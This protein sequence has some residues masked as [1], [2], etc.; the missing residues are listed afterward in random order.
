MATADE[1]EPYHS[2]VGR[3]DAVEAL[4]RRF[5]DVRSG[6]GGVTLLVGDTGVGKS[7][8]IAELVRDIRAHSVRVLVGR[9]FAVDDPPPFS[10]LQSVIESA[11]DD[12]LL[13]SDEDPMFGGGPMLIGFAPGLGEEAFPTPVGIEGRLLEVLGGT[14]S[15]G[16]TTPDQVLSGIADR[17]LEYT[18][19]GPT[20]VIFEDLE[21]ADKSSLAAVEF[22]AKELASRP[23]WILATTRPT[24]SLTGPAR[25][26]IERFETATRAEP[27]VLRPMTS[28]EAADYLRRNDP[29]REFSAEE[30]TR[31]FSE[32][33]G[34]PFLL[35]QLD[36][37][38]SIGREE[39]RGPL[40][41]LD[42][43][44]Q[45]TLE[46]AA[47]LGPEFPF[48]LLLGASEE[49]EEQLAEEVDR[50][51][52]RGLLFERPGELLEFPQDRLREEVYNFLSE[53]RRR[54]LHRRAGLALE[55]MGHVDPSRVYALARHYYLGREGPKSIQYNRIAAEI[56][57][58]SLAPDA[59]WDH[60]SRA[61][62]SQR[63]TSPNDLDGEAELVLGLARITEELGV[64]KE[65][66]GILRE[67]LEREPAD[68]RLSPGRRAALEIFLA[69]VL[70]DQGDLPGAAKLAHKV[71]ATPGLEDQLLVRL[72]AH[73]QL[74]QVSYYEGRYPEAVAH[75]TEDIEL[76]RKVGNPLLLMRAQVWRVA[77]LQMIGATEQAIAEAREVTAARDR[78]G[79]VRES[80]QAHLFLGDILADARSPPSDRKDAIGEFATAI[81]FAEKAKD[82]RR[83]GWALY[84]TTEMLREEGRLDQATETVQRAI[85]VLGQIGDQV[86]LSVAM[87][88]RGQVA[89]DRGNLD[90]AESDLLEA[91]R[92]LQGTNHMIEEIDV[93]LRLAQLRLVQGELEEARSR[94][95]E[96]ERLKLRWV[97]P[98]LVIEFDTLRRDLESRGG[99]AT[100]GTS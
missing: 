2:F 12:P 64:L 38:A 54:V 95:A 59:A 9:A 75:H 42:P 44:G 14:E 58:R 98:D 45:Q 37:R 32:S 46:V 15:R 24:L 71:L 72:G 68:A 88:V 40:P 85:V 55:A 52:G 41:P 6:T 70:T 8:L 47:V 21:R 60:F 94:V 34:N 56:D 7:T 3:G 11:R 96:L 20:V 86:G 53:R 63:L 77:A 74:G 78:L 19:H 57:E 67:F 50:L 17:F 35:Q 66:E 4:R 97:R 99:A 82:P 48:A 61:L 65:A 91:R 49:P 69:R 1:A 92:L 81:Q 27:V 33:G 100:P 29:T 84:K 28:D 18:R 10:L 26:R 30:I 43:N 79:S 93:V 22:F 13:R 89:M 25:S 39:S 31:R 90:G 76:A 16:A 23:L 62:E 51:V 36:R 83:V 80:A 87:K 5:E 73:H